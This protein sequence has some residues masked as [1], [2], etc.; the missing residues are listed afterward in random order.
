MTNSNPFQNA[1]FERLVDFPVVICRQCQYGVWPS[2]IE[3]HLQHAHRYISP[4]IRI[5]LGDEVR[6]WPEIAIDP[7]ELDIPP[8]RSQAIPQLIGPLDGWQCQLSPGSCL[9]T[10]QEQQQQACQRVQ[11]QQLFPKWLNSQYFAIID[12]N[13]DSNPIPTTPR[14]TIWDQATRQYAEYEKQAAEQIQHGHIDEANPWLR[15]TGWV[16]YLHS[17]SSTQLLEYIDMPA[18]DDAV[19]HSPVADLDEHAIQAI[20]TAMGQVGQISQ[21]SVIHTGVF[22]RMEAIRTERHQT[23]YQPLEAYQ[24][25]ETMT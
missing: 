10:I 25:L 20:W 22:V 13:K 24:D 11:C 2:Q 19:N 21:Q 9:Y 16:P 17:F 6:G 3:G 18:M 5:Q 12:E 8:I 7:I 1:Y 23:R 15:R 14:S 4:V